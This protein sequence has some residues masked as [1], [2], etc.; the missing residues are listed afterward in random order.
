MSSATTQPYVTREEYF[1][2]VEQNPG[3]YERLDG[4]IVAM[5]PETSANGLVKRQV[6][7]ALTRAVSAV[8]LRCDVYPESMAVSVGAG[9]DYVPDAFIRCGE[10]LPGDALVVSDPV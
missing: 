4:R 5:A 10:R 1:L 6:V 7:A 8:G 3:R 2:W 9:H